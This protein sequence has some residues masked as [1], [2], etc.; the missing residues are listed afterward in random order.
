MVFFSITSAV[1]NKYYSNSKMYF[2]MINMITFFLGILPFQCH[3]CHKEFNHRS[4]LNVH[5][6]I[7]SGQK[8]FKCSQCNK[9][10]SRKASLKHHL[11]THGIMD[12]D[13]QSN[14]SDDTDPNIQLTNI[15]VCFN[16]FILQI[17]LN[18]FLN[19]LL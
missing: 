6:R 10:F 2:Q 8:P 3:I 4:H 5:S 18:N 1:F 9:D 7:H 13:V 11:Q 17:K 14:Y 12:E 16:N 15:D 19:D